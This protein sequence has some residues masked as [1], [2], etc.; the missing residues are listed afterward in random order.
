MNITYELGEYLRL[1]MEKEYFDF[2][3]SNIYDYVEFFENFTN[4][5]ISYII[6]KIKELDIIS[7]ERLKKLYN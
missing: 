4:L 6:P 2:E 1:F 5:Y 7:K 3:F